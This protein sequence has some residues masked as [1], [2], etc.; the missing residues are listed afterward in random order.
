[1][2]FSDR[3]TKLLKTG[4]AVA[5]LLLTGGHYAFAQREEIETTLARSAAFG[6]RAFHATL[7]VAIG[8][9]NGEPC[10]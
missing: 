6:Q 7:P 4:S 2:T 9:F 5:L 8:W 10:L 3:R 1:M